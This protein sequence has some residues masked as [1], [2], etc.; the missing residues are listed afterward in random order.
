MVSELP[1]LPAAV[2]ASTAPDS[3]PV[4]PAWRQFLLPAISLLAGVSGA[5]LV[6]RVCIA[7]CSLPVA[8]RAVRALRGREV[9]IDLLDVIAVPEMCR[10][11]DVL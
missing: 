11:P 5:G 8:R 7:L 9:T 6:A 4:Q 1:E 3:S 2:E 10:I